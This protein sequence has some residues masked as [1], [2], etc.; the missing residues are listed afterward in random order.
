MFYLTWDFPVYSPEQ[1]YA[2]E[3]SEVKE[4]PLNLHCPIW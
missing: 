1:Y 4:M 3:L 2:G